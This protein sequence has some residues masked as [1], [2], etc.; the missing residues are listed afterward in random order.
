MPRKTRDGSSLRRE[1]VDIAA[2]VPVRGKCCIAP[3]PGE[4]AVCGT[5]VTYDRASLAELPRTS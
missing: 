3:Q 2:I 4:G 1:R 5:A